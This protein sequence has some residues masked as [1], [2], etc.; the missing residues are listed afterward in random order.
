L[1]FEPSSAYPAQTMMSSSPSP[2]P[3]ADGRFELGSTDGGALASTAVLG[4]VL[5]AL[6]DALGEGVAP[7]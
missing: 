2:A 5:G 6:V 1:T 7:L 3:T 4:A